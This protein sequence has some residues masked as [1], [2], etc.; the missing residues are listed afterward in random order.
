[1]NVLWEV[2]ELCLEYLHQLVLWGHVVNQMLLCPIQN[3][4]VQL[5]R[6]TFNFIIELIQLVHSEGY[7]YFLDYVHIA[8]YPSSNRDHQFLDIKNRNID[9]LEDNDARDITGLSIAQL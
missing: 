8:F 6:T 1:M 5:L 9:D 4:S 7:C 2:S 3:G